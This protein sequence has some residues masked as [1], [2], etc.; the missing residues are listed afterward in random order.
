M[1]GDILLLT[2][3]YSKTFLGE[4]IEGIQEHTAREPPHRTSQ[5]THVVSLSVYVEHTFFS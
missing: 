3:F 2:T 1:R 5:V 4:L